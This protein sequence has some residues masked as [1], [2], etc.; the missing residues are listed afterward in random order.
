MDKITIIKMLLAAQ[1][2]NRQF[3]AKFE[4]QKIKLDELTSLNIVSLENQIRLM[5]Q[6]TEQQCQLKQMSGQYRKMLIVRKK[7][8]N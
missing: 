2:E 5:N 4:Q 6:F 7:W 8:K 3:Q 1:N